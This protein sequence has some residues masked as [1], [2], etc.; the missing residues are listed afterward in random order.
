MKKWRHSWL[1]TTSLT[2]AILIICGCVT[3]N[4]E[5]SNYPNN[6]PAL[7]TTRCTLPSGTFTNIS[8]DAHYEYEN[9]Y[10]FPPPTLAQVLIND[11]SIIDVTHINIGT[12]TTEQLRIKA[13]GVRDGEEIYI[14][15]QLYN[16]NQSQCKNNRWTLVSKTT[17]EGFK[18]Y[19]Q[20][21]Y[22]PL[23]TATYLLATFGM[24]APISKW[25][26]YRIALNKNGALTVR[27]LNMQ[28]GLLFSIYTRTAM[29][30]DWFLFEPADIQK[31]VREHQQ[32]PRPS[33]TSQAENEPAPL[34]Q[35]CISANGQAANEM[36][37]TGIKF[38]RTQAYE[39]ALQCFLSA[40]TQQQNAS[41]EAM[42]QLCLMY[43]L[44]Q[45]TEPDMAQAKHWCARA[46]D[47]D[48][49]S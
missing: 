4:S 20:E 32:E 29:D 22:D 43:E 14:G 12:T 39:S 26:D 10:R 1:G 31:L 34:L 3:V 23:Y 45:G 15:E 9:S 2:C 37:N 28:S 13:F 6:W 35:D 30:D 42:W 18:G 47:F 24:G 16:L 46:A 27:R 5:Q 49:G 41:Q 11:F 8:S 33:P 25:W 36:Y 44:G 19:N 38:Y 40:A 21:D 17:H 48:K 7:T